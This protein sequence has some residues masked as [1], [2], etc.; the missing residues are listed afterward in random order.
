MLTIKFNKK[1]SD[2]KRN[3]LPTYPIILTSYALSAINTHSPSLTL[4]LL[5][6]RIWWDPNN[7]SKW[8]VGFNSTCKGLKISTFCNAKSKCGRLLHTF[9]M[10]L[11]IFSLHNNTFGRTFSLF[12]ISEWRHFRSEAFVLVVCCAVKVNLLPTFQNS[13]SIGV[14]RVRWLIQTK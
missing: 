2:E 1:F 5:T 13:I 12:E 6:W 11:T 9:Y 8:Q 7:A 4:T 14:S 3:Y 10:K